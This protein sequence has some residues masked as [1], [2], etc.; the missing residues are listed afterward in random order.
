MHVSI[1]TTA[2]PAPE[3][4]A[5]VDRGISQFNEQQPELRKVLPLCVFA[6][7]D[8]GQVV[9]GAVGRTCGQCGEL[10][11]LWV[12][13]DLRGQGIGRDLLSSFELEAARRGCRLVYLDTFTFHAPEFYGKSGYAVALAVDG[14]AEGISKFTMHKHLAAKRENV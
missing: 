11:Q 7:N 3:D 10:Q 13:S 4:K 2:D 1:F 5:V 14:Y 12:A 6:K 9:A 8:Q